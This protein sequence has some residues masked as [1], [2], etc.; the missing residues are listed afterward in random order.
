M[1]DGIDANPDLLLL[2]YGYPEIQKQFVKNAKLKGMNV[3]EIKLFAVNIDLDKKYDEQINW[4]KSFI[5]CPYWKDRTPINTLNKIPKMF[6]PEN[7]FGFTPMNV[8]WDWQNEA[9]NQLLYSLIC[10]IGFEDKTVQCETEAEKKNMEKL[11]TFSSNGYEAFNERWRDF[12]KD[13]E[14]KNQNQENIEWSR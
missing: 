3:R 14:I 5:L 2:S 10:P 6:R 11:K 7:I 1:K 12:D 4:L 9:V 13:K 8:N